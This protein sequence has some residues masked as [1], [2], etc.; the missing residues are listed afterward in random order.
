MTDRSIRDWLAAIGLDRYAELFEQNRIGIDVLQHIGEQ[1]LKELGVPLGDRRRLLVAIGTR[2]VSSNLVA[3]LP[4]H[5]GVS[6]TTAERRQLTVLFCDLVGSTEL[7]AT[8][9]PEELRALM[10]A[11]RRAASRVVARSGGYVAQHLG[12][13]LMAYFGW[14]RADEDVAAQAVSAALD[15]VDAIKTVSAPSPLR[16]R[17]GIAT[18]PVVVGDTGSQE[19]D[20]ARLAVGETPNLAA[21]LQGL[22]GTDQVVVAHSTRRLAAEAFLYAD[23]G[24]R[25]LKGVAQ[26]QRCWLIEGRAGVQ[27]RFEA[28]RA[29]SLTPLVGRDAEIQV[30]LDRWQQA[31]EGDGQVVLLSGEPGIGKSRIVHALRERIGRTPHEV[32]LTQCSPLHGATAFYPI[33]ESL[34]VWAGIT[35]EDGPEQKLDKLDALLERM[36]MPVSE[37]G[38]LFAAALSI[39]ALDRYP[40]LELTPQRQRERTV[41]AL[42]DQVI[43]FTRQGPLMFIV[44]DAHWADP[45]TLDSLAGIVRRVRGTRALAIVTYRPEFDATWRH[46]PHVMALALSR[47]DQRAAADLAGKVIGSRALP[48]EILDQIVTK[49]DGVP[50]FVEELTKA[51][52]DAE[53]TRER[54][55]RF[56]VDVP[57][58]DL[59]VPATLRDSL[60]ARLDR[61]GPFKEVAQ[62]AACVGREFS[63]RMLEAVTELTLDQVRTALEALVASGLVGRTTGDSD[64]SYSFRHALIQDAAHASLLNAR[65]QQLHNRIAAELEAQWP[66]VV[67]TQP[68]LM[69]H[70]HAGA[71]NVERAVEFMSVAGQNAIERSANLEAVRILRRAIDLLTALPETTQRLECELQLQTLLA[72]PLMAV[73]VYSAPEVGQLYER[74]YQL[75]RRLEKSALMYPALAGVASFH[76]TRAELETS[77]NLSGEMLH[78][79]EADGDKDATMEAHRLLG[80]TR[81]WMGDLSGGRQHLAKVLALYEASRAQSLATIYGQDH[82][83]SALCWDAWSLLYLGYPDQAVAARRAALDAASATSHMFSRLYAPAVTMNVLQ[84]IGDTESM[85]QAAGELVQTAEEHALTGWAAWGYTGG[86]WARACLGDPA[87]GMEQ[88]TKGL[89]LFRAA[90]VTILQPFHLAMAADVCCTL[91]RPDEARH[92]LAQTLD[93]VERGGQRWFQ[94]EAYRLMGALMSEQGM[95]AEA[96][97]LFGKALHVARSQN[98]KGWELRVAISYAR[99]MQRQR[100]AR[101]G[102]RL[103]RPIYE[104]Y[105]EGF[106]TKDLKEAKALLDELD[107]TSSAGEG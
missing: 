93:Q 55:G 42:A 1:D 21:R 53:V 87:A 56:G 25:T 33:V 61:L 39:H 37:V 65:R 12:D 16:V 30:L 40:R 8:L 43:A 44:E 82:R 68:E 31:C 76:V 95:S 74:S 36:R 13:G 26:P 14:P 101:N 54:G 2:G 24:C 47:L 98:A 46:E 70:H 67:Q 88:I 17:V 32:L 94:A 52:L 48:K 92:Y 96:E 29:A 79:A 75:A 49:T 59:A 83:M 23:L 4:A 6:G 60:A 85:I 81:Q 78:L 106:D 80:M 20:A 72:A 50:L 66:E 100:R 63:E 90:E 45:S 3:P 105:T 15:I 11:Y 62:T 102:E 22:A 18:G 19:D 9:D 10:T 64:G 91:H 7:A 71:G 41:E 89:A 77:L 97:E 51:V 99:L 84:F 38:P 107:P 86:G 27:S 73:R 35:R 103:L 34:S 5:G 69:A 58:P 57:F 28:S 104:W